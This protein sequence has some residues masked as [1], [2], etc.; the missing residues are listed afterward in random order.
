MIP[1]RSVS[2][3]HD[4]P[5]WVIRLIEKKEEKMLQRHVS[6]RRDFVVFTFWDLDGDMIGGDGVE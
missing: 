5:R 1:I 2:K 4:I 3:L 6:C